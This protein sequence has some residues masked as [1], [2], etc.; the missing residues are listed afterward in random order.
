MS[1]L[2]PPS[3]IIVDDEPELASLQRI[4]ERE[5]LWC[6][7]FYRS[8]IGSRVFKETVDKHLL[9]ITDLRMP[10]ICGI[11]LAKNIREFEWKTKI[12]LKTAF[13]IQD[14]EDR[15][16]F[17]IARID[18]LIQEPV[19]FS[20]LREMINGALKKWLIILSYILL[21]EIKSIYEFDKILKT[22]IL[23]FYRNRVMIQYLLFLIF[24]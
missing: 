24:W 23:Y 4:F 22:N 1:S 8:T 13:D 3:L 18:K 14:L 11:D 19:W 7:L 9:I 12:F 16:D 6:S 15:A 17:K 2:S 5:R 10:G 21:P 20:D